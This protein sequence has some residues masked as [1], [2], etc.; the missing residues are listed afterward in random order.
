MSTSCPACGTA[1]AAEVRPAQLSSGNCTECGRRFTIVEELAASPPTEGTP[2]AAAPREDQ[3]AAGPSFPI[4]CPH[5]EGELEI[6]PTPGGDIEG[7]C[8]GCGAQVLY[9]LESPRP[10][11]EDHGP[12]EH[13]RARPPGPPER[14]GAR[15]CRECG[16]VLNFTTGPDGLVHGECTSC[17]NRFTLPARRAGREGPSRGGFGGGRRFPGGYAGGRSWTRAERGPRRPGGG[18]RRGP[19]RRDDEADDER[20]RRRPRRS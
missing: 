2:A 6:A 16:G 12:M 17:G 3:P 7:R 15:P 9:R 10:R 1:L 14:S 13:R 18:F 20:P 19:R 5:C 8:G 4:A 11:G